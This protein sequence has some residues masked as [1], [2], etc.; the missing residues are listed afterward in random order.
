MPKNSL[1]LLKGSDRRVITKTSSVES[2]HTSESGTD[3]IS[4]FS[5]IVRYGTEVRAVRYGKNQKNKSRITEMLVLATYYHVIYHPHLHSTH[6]CSRVT[7]TDTIRMIL[8]RES[9]EL[10]EVTILDGGVG[11]NL[12]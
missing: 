11:R 7:H 4:S 8:S 3:R 6:M 9:F 12:R 10:S 1:F 2:V 5:R